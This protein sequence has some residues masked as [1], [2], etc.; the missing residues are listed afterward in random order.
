MYNAYW[1]ALQGE[2]AFGRFVESIVHQARLAQ[3][4]LFAF[5]LRVNNGDL[6]CK[7]GVKSWFSEFND[8]IH[9]DYGGARISL[10]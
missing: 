5:L 4:F 3:G 8:K 10:S 1:A 9:M 6:N 7:F 2:F